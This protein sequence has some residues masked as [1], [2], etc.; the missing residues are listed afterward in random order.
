MTEALGYIYQV[1]DGFINFVFNTAT[2]TE[3]VTLGW[4][5]IST[6]I[7]SFVLSNILVIP[8]IGGSK[9]T[10]GGKENG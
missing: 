8:S 6:F 5:L 3:G 2:I 7:I 1:F 10:K 4:V 9:E